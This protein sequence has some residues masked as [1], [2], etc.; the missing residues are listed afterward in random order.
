[1]ASVDTVNDL[2]RVRGICGRVT[3]TW[4]ERLTARGRE[5]ATGLASCR[6]DCT[7]GREERCAEAD[8][9]VSVS[10][11]ADATPAPQQTARTIPA[12]KVNPP[13]KPARCDGPTPSD[14]TSAAKSGGPAAGST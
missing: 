10:G 1:M 2:P 12:A 9:D 6:V 14:A 4:A 5:A 7:D 8:A 11:A 3:E 13:I